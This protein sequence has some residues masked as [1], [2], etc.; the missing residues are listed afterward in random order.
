MPSNWNKGQTKETNLSIKRISDTMKLRKINNFKIWMDRMK[1]EGKI[2]SG[3]PTLKKDGDL[4]ELVGV[5]LGDGHIY[6]YDR[7]EEL[8]I[9][10]NANNPGF[11]KRYSSLMEK[12]FSRKPT[13]K[14]H[15]KKTCIRIRIYEKHIQERLGVP[16][17][18]RLNKKIII[19][20]WIFNK[21]AYM[22]RYLRG[23]Y[24]AEGSYSV[25]KP[26]YTYKV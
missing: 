26:T 15:S 12:V 23:L 8:S 17:S 6:K 5:V 19:P 25:H 20:G 2:K 1:A 9:F 10:S 16:F 3:Y 7:T 24:E 13:I 4:A 22:I 11:I 18:P 21:R 14:S